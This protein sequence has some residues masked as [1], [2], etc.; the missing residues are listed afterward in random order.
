MME[1]KPHHIYIDK[2]H[3]N[4]TNR[5]NIHVQQSKALNNTSLFQFV[6]VSQTQQSTQPLTIKNL[7]T[8][9]HDSGRQYHE[10]YATGN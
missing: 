2:N 5:Q 3:K 7:E 4:K 9:Q 10:K 1:R 8:K 6:G